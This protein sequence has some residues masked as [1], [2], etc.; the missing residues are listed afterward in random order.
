VVKINVNE[1]FSLSTS[2]LLTKIKN[3]K[4]KINKVL[5]K[6]EIFEKLMGL[7]NDKL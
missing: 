4:N 6:K 7:K 1:Q 3:W 5:D 2:S